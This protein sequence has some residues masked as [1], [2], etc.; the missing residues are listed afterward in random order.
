MRLCESADGYNYIYTHVD[1][2][3]I[4]TKDPEHWM[5]MIKGAFL[6]KESGELIIMNTKTFAIESIHHVESEFGITLPKYKMP[7]P[8][9]GGEGGHPETSS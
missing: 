1:N 6:M 8:T 2:F 3:K 9:L 4:I 5:E 7:L